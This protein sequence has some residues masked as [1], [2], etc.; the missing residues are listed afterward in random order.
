MMSNQVSTHAKGQRFTPSEAARH[1][2]VKEK[3][4]AVWRCT[5]RYN[6]PFLKAGGKVVYF[7]TDLDDWISRRMNGIS[8]AAAEE[9]NS[10]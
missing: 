10:E 1:L 9:G 8:S 7:E 2:G 3:T 4:L 5:G 6:I